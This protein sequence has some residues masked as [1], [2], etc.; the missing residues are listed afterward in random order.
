MRYRA[1]TYVI[2]AAIAGAITVFATASFAQVAVGVDVD[3]YGARVANGPYAYDYYGGVSIY[4][5]PPTH[6]IYGYP[7]TNGIYGGPTVDLF[8]YEGPNRGAVERA[9]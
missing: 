3:P 4:N 5:Y 8:N 7:P 1:L 6:G 2:A 9:H